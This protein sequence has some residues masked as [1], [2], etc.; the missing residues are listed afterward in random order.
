[1]LSPVVTRDTA[2]TAKTRNPIPAT[3]PRLMITF[4]RTIRLVLR[5]SPT[6]KGIVSRSSPNKIDG[7]KD[8]MLC[9]VHGDRRL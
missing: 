1:M 7:G 4:C 5:L 2:K 3:T 6:T 9:L 8:L